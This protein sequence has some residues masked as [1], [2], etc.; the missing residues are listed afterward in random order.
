MFEGKDM[1]KIALI[2]L[3]LGVAIGLLVGVNFVPRVSSD[4]WN[5]CAKTCAI[6]VESVAANG[7][8]DCKEPQ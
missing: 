4:Q 1:A 5:K 3:V 8:C 7:I 6:G 2:G